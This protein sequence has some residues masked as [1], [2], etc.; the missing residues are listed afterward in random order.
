[1]RAGISSENNS[2]S[3]LGISV[4]LRLGAIF[5]GGLAVE[6]LFPAMVYLMP[7]KAVPIGQ[8][9]NDPVNSVHVVFLAHKG[10]GRARLERGAN[11]FG[12]ETR[13]P[14]RGLQRH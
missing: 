9:G 1:M 5:G 10:Q 8:D 4:G 13:K 12:V 7:D 6:H 14:A 11:L 2:I 3:K